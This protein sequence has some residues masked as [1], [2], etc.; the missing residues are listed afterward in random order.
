GLRAG[1][2]EQ[3]GLR[4]A[5]AAAVAERS[6]RLLGADV[7]D[8]APPPLA[9]AECE[10]L[11]EQEGR[12]QV[13]GDRLGPVTRGELVHRRSDVDAGGVDDD[14]H[15]AHLVAE[16]VDL[17]FVA[18]VGDGPGR[19]FADLVN[20]CLQVGT[21]PGHQADLGAGTGERSGH[22]SADAGAGPGDERSST[23]EREHRGSLADG[24]PVG[25]VTSRRWLRRR[26]QA[27]RVSE[28]EAP[29]LHGS[30]RRILIY[31]VTGS[32]KTTLARSIG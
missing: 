10:A 18:D 24:R 20:G 25:T 15:L 32:G 23:R 1:Q 17:G 19:P 6:P 8:A 9:H 26:W 4:G 16:V 11:A 5:V 3:P 13:H 22:G 29:A 2:A 14:V 12:R 7:Q 30:A 21:G 28:D 31:G 27:R